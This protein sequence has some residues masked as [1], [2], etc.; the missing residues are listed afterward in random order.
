MISKDLFITVTVN[1]IAKKSLRT[2]LR[3]LVVI[4]FYGSFKNFCKEAGIFSHGFYLRRFDER[5]R[6]TQ[7]CC[8]DIFLGNFKIKAIGQYSGCTV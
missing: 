8:C 1:S 7:S 6:D 5:S 4:W 2:T 3:V